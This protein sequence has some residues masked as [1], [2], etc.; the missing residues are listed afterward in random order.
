[1]VHLHLWCFQLT[2]VRE[3]KAKFHPRLAQMISEKRDLLQS[4]SSN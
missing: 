4:I 3:E 1:M 2:A